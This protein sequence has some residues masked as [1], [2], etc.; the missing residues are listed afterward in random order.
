MYASSCWFRFEI[1]ARDA[2]GRAYEI[3]PTDLAL[4][5]TPSARAFLAGGDHFRRTYDTA[6]LRRHV[7]DLGRLACQVEAGRAATI[8]ITLFEHAGASADDG[9]DESR[10]RG[11]GET[12]SCGR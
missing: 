7:G 9:G 8:E 10:R 4:R 6:A 2:N 1:L 5:A 11:T 12:V 3:A